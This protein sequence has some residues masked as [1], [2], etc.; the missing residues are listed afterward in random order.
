MSEQDSID[1]LINDAFDRLETQETEVEEEA[2][3]DAEV[4]EAEDE[5]EAHDDETEEVE[6]GDE[7]EEDEADDEPRMIRVRVNGE[8]KLVT[9]QEAAN[10]Y[11][12]QEYI[13]QELDRTKEMQRQ[14]QAALQAVS[15]RAQEIEAFRQRVQEQGFI[16]PPKRPEWNAN[17]P[18]GSMEAKDRYERELETYQQQQAQLN[19][20]QEYQRAMTEQQRA[21]MLKAEEQRLV[22]AI[23]EFKDPQK[24]SAVQKEL[25]EYAQ[26]QGFSPEELA[27]VMD[28][29][30][31]KLLHKAMKYDRLMAEGKAKAE[32]PKA[33]AVK[34]GARRKT[35]PA[36]IR[37][38]K[39]DKAVARG[40]I[41]DIINAAFSDIS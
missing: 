14:V 30:P 10:S 23:P 33:K 12:G 11:A 26:A 4:I 3:E 2:V 40:S 22:E 27:Q 35:D 8:E 28:H 5:E 32:K 15:E 38:Q 6:E 24:R 25:V 1:G 13:R 36:A 39:L 19:Q 41:D 20:L 17:D 9:E 16:A 7:E 37:K 31:L 34:P 18:I 29:R 21:Q